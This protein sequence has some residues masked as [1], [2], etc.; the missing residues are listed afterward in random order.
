MLTPWTSLQMMCPVLAG[1]LQGCP[2]SGFL[3]AAAFSPF[4]CM[5]A[6][7]TD[8]KGEAL[9]R[10]CA[11]DVGAS[12]RTIRVLPKYAVIFDLA[13]KCANL[14]LGMAKC[15]VVP[16]AESCT[17]EVINQVLGYIRK[18]VPKWSSFRVEAKAKYFGTWHGPE[19]RDHNWNAPVAKWSSRSTAL[20]RERIAP[21]QSTLI[22][23]MRCVVCLT[24]VGQLAPPPPGMAKKEVGMINKVLH[25]PPNTFSLASASRLADV[26]LRPPTSAICLAWASHIRAAHKTLD[27]RFGWGFM[28]KEK[29]EGEMRDNRWK[30][31]A[32]CSSLRYATIDVIRG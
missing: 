5:M 3:F 19:V 7:C 6:E 31:D 2:L 13:E 21:S 4:L 15:V 27:W 12:L 32:Y 28:E 20:A 10:A 29:G 9:T 26:G 24:Y 25:S 1:A 14:T 16:I 22:Y 8:K 30:S 18:H 17:Q 23:N 11:D